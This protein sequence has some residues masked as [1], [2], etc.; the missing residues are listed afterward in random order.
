MS[1]DNQEWLILRH[2]IIFE[3]IMLMVGLD[4]LDSCR[5]VCRSWNAMIVNKIRENPTKHWGP[6]IGRRIERSWDIKDYYPSDN[7]IA[8]AKLLGEHR[9]QSFIV[10]ICIFLL[11]NRGIL[12]LDAFES[13]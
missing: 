10:L 9:I 8:R 13:L 6:I 4:S 11:E 1:Q 12:T 5:L 2:P 7:L 3:T